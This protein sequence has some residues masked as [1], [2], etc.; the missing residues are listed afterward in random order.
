MH[1]WVIGAWD[2][3]PAG[4]TTFYNTNWMLWPSS[5]ETTW[6]G[7]SSPLSLDKYFFRVELGK[8]YE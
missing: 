5:S 3:T 7:F 6:E 2:Q 4:N 1:K 8:V